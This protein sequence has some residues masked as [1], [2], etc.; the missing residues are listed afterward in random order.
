MIDRNELQRAIDLHRRS[1]SLLRWL[2]TS[3][4][5]GVIRIDRAHDYM[6]E[7][8]AARDWIERHYLNLPLDC[9]PATDELGAFAQFFA[10]YL[11]T[12]FD[13]VKNPMQRRYSECGCP[14]SM[15]SYMVAASHL[16]PK[17][18]NRRDK[19]RA[20]KLKI[21][22]L[23]QLALERDSRLDEQEAEKLIDSPDAAMEVSL[24]AYGQQLMA[25]MRGISEGP[26]VLAL[27]REIAWDKRGAPKKEFQLEAEHILDAQESL[28]KRLVD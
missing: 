19:M 1:Y 11:T 8:E 18:V 13:F 28:K 9:R 14:C 2:G 15:C 20:R 22:A 26:A 23:K 16:Q 24:V 10:T 25:R 4:S 21:Y 3:V 12:S 27:W 17:K 5:K 6:D 7:A